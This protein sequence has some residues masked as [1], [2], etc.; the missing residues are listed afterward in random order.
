MTLGAGLNRARRSDA[1][2]PASLTWTGEPLPEDLDM[3]GNLELRL[4]AA[5]TAWIALVQDIAPTAAA[6]TSPPASCGPA[7]ERSR[8]SQPP[9]RSRP[10]RVT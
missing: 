2:P 1:D 10:A 3:I 5:D 4:D 8:G 7:C 6:P 9:R